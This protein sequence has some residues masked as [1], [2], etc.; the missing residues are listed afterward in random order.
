MILF[1][2]GL[3][4]TVVA[5]GWGINE[6]ELGLG[7]MIAISPLVIA[8]IGFLFSSYSVPTGKVGVSKRLV[9]TIQVRS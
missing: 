7:G 5:L 4:L 3:I 6:G 2:I 9:V 8:L 1:I